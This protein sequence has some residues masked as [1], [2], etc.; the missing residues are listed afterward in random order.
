LTTTDDRDAFVFEAEGG[1]PLRAANFRHR[2]WSR[3][4]ERAR[5]PGLTFHHLRH[6]AVG[7]LIDAN[8]HPAVMQHRIG[9]SSIWTTLDVY[10]HVLPDT[11]ES[12]T[13]HLEQ[14]FACP[15][16]QWTET[17]PTERVNVSSNEGN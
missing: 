2:V 10:G 16:G 5:L 9:H 14:L 17:L 4:T 15:D 13:K 12:A 8:A 6:S 11:D 7:F 1:G 3:A